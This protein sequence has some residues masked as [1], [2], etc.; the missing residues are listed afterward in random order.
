[1]NGSKTLKGAQGMAVEM[2]HSSAVKRKSPAT[3]GRSDSHLEG[4]RLSWHSNWR[5]Q[6]YGRQ[7][8]PIFTS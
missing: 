2:T 6:S 8:L 7:N 5:I 3:P 1:M 4:M